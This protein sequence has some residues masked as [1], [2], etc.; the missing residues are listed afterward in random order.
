[1]LKQVCAKDSFEDEFVAM[2]EDSEHTF[3]EV[4]ANYDEG[5]ML[6]TMYGR[7]SDCSACPIR[8]AALAM[9]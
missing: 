8:E 4:L 2:I 5:C 9:A 6:C 1:M 7:N 3:D